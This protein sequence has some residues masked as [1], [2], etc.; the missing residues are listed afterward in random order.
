MAV[1]TKANGLKI[2]WRVWVSISGMM[3]VSIKVSTRTTK[4]TDLVFTPG[5]MVVTMKDI[6]TEASSMV[7]VLTLCRKK[8][9][10]SLDFGKMVREFSG[11]TSNK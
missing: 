6:G 2:T 8:A 11:L 10:L 9:K 1:G 7:S 3:G 5:Q 4:S